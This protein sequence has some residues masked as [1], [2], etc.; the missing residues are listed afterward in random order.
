MQKKA[1]KKTSGTIVPFRLTSRSLR[2]F[3]FSFLLMALL[4]LQAM[5]MHAEII[6]PDRRIDW[7]P[8][9]VGVPGGIPNR[10]TVFASVADYGAVGDDSTDNR[11]AFQAAFN[12]CPSGQVV[13]IP[14][15]VFRINGTLV[16]PGN[17]T[18]RG[19][20]PSTVIK[21]V[22]TG[23]GLFRFGANAIPWS[24]SQLATV[25][26]TIQSGASAGS[27]QIAVENAD[28]ISVGMYLVISELNDPAFVTQAGAG[29][30]AVW[31]SGWGDDGARARGEIVEVTSVNGT[32]IGITPALTSDY[33]LTPWA[34]RFTAQCRW[35]GVEN[36]KTYATNSGTMRNFYFQCAAYCWV[37]DVECDYADGDH[38]TFDFS[39]RCEVR[40]SY[41]HDAYIHLPGQWDNPI[42]LRYK[43]SRCLIVDN[44]LRRLHLGVCLEWGACGNVIAYNYFL[45]S[46]DQRYG[47]TG[48]RVL[49]ACISANHGAHPQF[50]L[51]EGNVCNKI[52]PDNYW[53]SSS[54]N[55]IYRNHVTGHGYANPP[56]NGRGEV[57][58]GTVV[59]W[60]QQVWAINIWDGQ[61]FY[62]IIGNV[63]GD[64]FFVSHNAVRKVVHPQYRGYQTYTLF[65]YG[66]TG[67]SDTGTGTQVNNP[68][69]TMIDHG[70][71]DVISGD[72]EWDPNIAD[73]ALPAS[74][75]FTA[76]PDWFGNVPWPPIGPDVPG[77]V[78]KIPAQVRFENRPVIN[79]FT[80]NPA[81]IVQGQ[82]SVLSWTVTAANDL[83]I[84]HGLG[85]VSGTSTTVTPTATT[86]YT[87]TATNST[88]SSTADVTVTV[89]SGSGGGDAG[90]GGGGGGGG[91]FIAT[92]AHGLVQWSGLLPL[93]LL[94][95]GLVGWNFGK[96]KTL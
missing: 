59:Q 7:S 18:I 47:T 88:G 32:T 85:I 93:F 17:I 38:G 60:I 55:T 35:S 71:W 9:T 72:V 86:T 65:A 66:Y 81:V 43:T 48:Q 39:Y 79:S 14:A 46:F 10:Q 11:A 84:D 44:T 31:V 56:F 40:G 57:D 75:C 87:L 3:N 64:D 54:H 12:A 28:G 34:T 95:L 70:N 36:L 42:A 73:H 92:V 2:P 80:A 29:G 1:L 24:L 41:F 49:M 82:S 20:G 16:V 5:S 37:K 52:E 15:G 51:I 25:T 53:G 26:T 74:L 33:T 13:T 91:C 22:G 6:P 21:P 83:S 4:L 63:L 76:K 94:G 69:P 45:E 89:Q 27:S 30:N 19:A 62:N 67:Y 8:A 68:V 61:T 96:R 58:T 90:S 23:D 78:N 50:N 77:Q